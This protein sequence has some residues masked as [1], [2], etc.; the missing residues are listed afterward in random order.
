M[1]ESLG[2]PLWVVTK[3]GTR[4]EQRE[5]N[6]NRVAHVTRTWISDKKV[7]SSTPFGPQGGA[8]HGHGASVSHGVP[9][10][11][12][13]YADTELYIQIADAAA[14]SHC[15]VCNLNV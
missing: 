5:D 1:T 14:P 7:K 13:A 8:D 12:P 15:C 4:V 2:T 9:V 6:G 3:N 11:S 10:Y